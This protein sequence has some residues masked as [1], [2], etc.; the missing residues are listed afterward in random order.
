LDASCK[1]FT[2]ATG[3]WFRLALG[4][5]GSIEY[6]GVIGR[7]ATDRNLDHIG[8]AR[9]TA[10]LHGPCHERGHPGV[11][12]QCGEALQCG[13]ELQCGEALQCGKALQCVETLHRNEVPQG[14][15]NLCGDVGIIR[16][17]AIGG[18]CSAMRTES[19]ARVI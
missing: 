11:V 14:Y 5:R 2:R 16:V 18:N 8:V 7:V 1:G 13:E 12:L 10:R 19:G 3:A 9:G 17:E 6:E 15:S 4:E